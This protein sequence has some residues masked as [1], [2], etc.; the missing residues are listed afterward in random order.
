MTEGGG[1]QWKL[2]VR[3]VG[4][5][6]GRTND[7]EQLL[8]DYDRRVGPGAPRGAHGATSREWPSCA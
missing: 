6:L 8:I 3:L 7:A 2:N 5:A 1:G 4:E